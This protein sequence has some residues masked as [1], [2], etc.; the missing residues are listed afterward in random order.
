MSPI[1]AAVDMRAA[2]ARVE[3]GGAA[4]EQAAQHT[5]RRRGRRGCGR[6]GGEKKGPGVG[7]IY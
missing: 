6:R 4:R 5:S 2:R 3:K 1:G 7:L